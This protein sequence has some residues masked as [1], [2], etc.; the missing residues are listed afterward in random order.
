VVQQKVACFNLVHHVAV[1]RGFVFQ[2]RVRG[3]HVD[4]RFHTCS[5]QHAADAEHRVADR[6]AVAKRRQHLM[7]PRH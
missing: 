2:S 5:A 6:I 7:D 3:F 4:T 1:I